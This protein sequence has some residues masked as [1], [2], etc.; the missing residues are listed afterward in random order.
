[1]VC[2]MFS[3]ICSKTITKILKEAGVE[4]EI[5]E[6]LLALVKRDLAL[7]KHRSI[8]KK[9]MTAKRGQQ[10]TTSKI[11]KLSK[12]YKDKGVLSKDWKYDR[13]KAAQWII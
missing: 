13:S 7:E 1:M 12:Y 9:D 10:L 3:L 2:Q 6:D 5:P 11:S 4:R 8:N